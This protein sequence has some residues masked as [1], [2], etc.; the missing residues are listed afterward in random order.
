VD[1]RLSTVRIAGVALLLFSGIILGVGIHHLVATGTCSSTGYS[2]NYGPVPHCPSGTG[3]WFG[4]VF[5]GIVG[6]LVGS[7]MAGGTGLVFASIFGGIGFGALTLAFDSH[8]SSGTQIFGAAFGGAFAVVGV[9]AGIAVLSAALAALRQPRSAGPAAGGSK[10]RLSGNGRSRGARPPAAAPP[11]APF[12]GMPSPAVSTP[13][14]SAPGAFASP[15]PSAGS[16]AGAVD[17]LTKLGELH[18]RGLLTD[19]EFA[20]A[21]SKLLGAV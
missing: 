11:P 12:Q 18:Q 16:A 4:F 20:E 6:A 5:G 3:A 7:L 17:S 2:A 10:T 15:T 13:A 19:S 14:M 21:K 9:I 8:A 1:E